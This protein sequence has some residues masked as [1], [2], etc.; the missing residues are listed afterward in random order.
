MLASTVSSKMLAIVAQKEGFEFR[1]T[2]TGF[3]WVLFAILIH[4][5]LLLNI[6]IWLT[7]SSDRWLGNAAKELESQ[8]F[9]AELLVIRCQLCQS[10]SVLTLLV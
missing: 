9:D 5:H 2:L 6:F 4:L 8:G 7:S 3:K 1:E 10:T